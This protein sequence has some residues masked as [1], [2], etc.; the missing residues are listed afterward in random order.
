MTT[1]REPT[2]VA[3]RPRPP[4]ASR[5][6]A[7]TTPWAG[8]RTTS[9]WRVAYAVTFVT[10]LLVGAIAALVNPAL[11][12]L[13]DAPLRDGSWS[14]AY[15][16]AFDAASP[17]LAPSRTV[18][19]LI[20]SVLFGQGRPG[21]LIGS[22]GWLYSR[23]EY[24]TVGDAP[25]AIE[26]WAERIALVR[27]TLAQQG[28]TLVVAP[29]PS[30]ASIVSAHAPAPLPAAAAARYDL[31]LS[32]L[33]ER[34]VIVSDLR[35]AL[36]S[37]GDDR[38]AFLR[39]DT[40]WTPAGAAAATR[41]VAATLRAHTPFDGMDASG[42]E[43]TLGAP[44]PHWGDLTVFLDLG[45]LLSTLG[46]APDL[47]AVPQTVSLAAPGSDLFAVVE[48]PVVLVGTSYSADPS[49]NTVGSLREALG[50]DVL[51]AALSGLGPWEPMRRYLEG[52]ALRATPPRVVVWEIPE[53]YLTLEGY[54]PE[55][56]SW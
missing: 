18:W 54:V 7:T 10:V 48:V 17:L 5:A 37:L 34:G 52:E 27:D 43:T 53:R 8:V 4:A 38:A 2:T 9:R 25:A 41:A 50:S 28:A 44:A 56:V 30:K 47:L 6:T 51:D 33:H 39:T 16:Q 40:H 12:E 23:E 46:P 21:V 22:D 1:Q 20:D 49:W 55:T 14:E 45:P 19:G 15:Q 13:P 11:R 35:A 29:V 32:E 3:T 36:R 26:R 31:L 42:F 24:A